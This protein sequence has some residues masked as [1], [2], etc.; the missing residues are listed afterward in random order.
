MTSLTNYRV[1]YISEPAFLEAKKKNRRGLSAYGIL[2]LAWMAVLFQSYISRIFFSLYYIYLIAYLLV[3]V[4]LS[5][6]LVHQLVTFI[7]LRTLEGILT[8]GE[9]EI[10][11]QAE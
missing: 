3:T 5:L 9:F 7:T 6:L 11:K 2:W 1:R 10:D 8:L 4:V